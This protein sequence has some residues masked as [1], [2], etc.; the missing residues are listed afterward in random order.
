MSKR[1]RNSS[2]DNEENL[3]DDQTYRPTRNTKKPSGYYSEK[4]FAASLDQ[5]LV[6]EQ[7]KQRLDGDATENAYEVLGK[8]AFISIITIAPDLF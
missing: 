6:E 8:D 4:T 1:R 3:D 7:R 5:A 2:S